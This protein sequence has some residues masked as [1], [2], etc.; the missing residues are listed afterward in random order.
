MEP[1]QIASEEKGIA[2]NFTASPDIQGVINEV[3][4]NH[5]G[6]GAKR[7]GGWPKGRPRNPTQP[8]SGPAS[9][10]G[11]NVQN[12]PAPAP[13]ID[14]E[15]VRKSVES[16]VKAIDKINQRKLYR[17]ALLASYEDKN[18]AAAFAGET[19]ATVEEIELVS[20]LSAELCTKYEILGQYA[21]EILFL[22]AVGGYTI[23]SLVAYSKLG[24][25][26]SDRKEKEKAAN[27]RDK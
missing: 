16:L 1:I 10:S 7:K 27:D 20:N 4:S 3:G 17:L 12:T 21:P 26:I 5:L 8:A 6:A 23:K 9:G 18:Y 22:F 24:E 14:K 11:A 2:A 25:M 19:A 15:L 13:A